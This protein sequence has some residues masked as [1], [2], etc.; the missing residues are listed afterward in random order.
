MQMQASRRYAFLDNTA[1]ST[2]NARLWHRISLAFFFFFF[3]SLP[4]VVQI[5]AKL[6]RRKRPFPN[7]PGLRLRFPHTFIVGVATAVV[8]QDRVL[9]GQ[10]W[11]LP[12]IPALERQRQADF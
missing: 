3:L 12:L 9:A 10:W 11:H 1:H 4:W 2:E 6:W 8:F 5:T 7:I